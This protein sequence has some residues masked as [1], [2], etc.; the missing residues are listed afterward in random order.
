MNTELF[1]A[2]KI[3]FKNDKDKTLT[4]PIV[5]I[6]VVGVALSLIV[7]IL[8]ISI[9]SGFKKEIS[10]KI[11]DFESNIQLVKFNPNRSLESSPINHPLPYLDDIKRTENVKYINTFATK[12]GVIKK[13]DQILGAVIKGVSFDNNFEDLEKYIIEG[14][15]PKLDSANNSYDVVISQRIANKLYLKLGDSFYMYFV[16]DPPRSRKFNI[17]G[18]YKTDFPEY[19]NTFIIGDIKNI[20]RLNE[21]EAGQVGGY[22]VKLTDYTKLDKATE[23]IYNTVVLNYNKDSEPI[24]VQSLVDKKSSIF[25]WLKLQDMNVLFILV[26]MIV[27]ACFNMISGILIII[28]ERTNMIGILKALGANNLNIRK[29]F[30]YQGFFILMRG[31]FWGNLVGLSIGFVQ[32]YFHII[33]LDP[34]SYLL[35]NVP[36]NIDIIS[37]LQLNMATIAITF[38]VLLLPS[39]VITNISPDKA[40]KFE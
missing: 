39:V 24:R 17:C 19:D 26:I 3:F 13:D 16:Q 22:E 8:S 31:L 25:D 9:I 15:I 30:L 23:D 11:F 4:R 36:V 32:Q 2:R 10:S 6:A 40:V 1:I 14:T 20:Q 29:I 27:V 37:V 28:L 5:K 18:I 34:D 38:L 12:A 35:S 33:K 7:M 21:W